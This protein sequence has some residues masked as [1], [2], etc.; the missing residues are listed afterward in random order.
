MC[1]ILYI[2]VTRSFFETVLEVKR[3]E[4]HLCPSSPFHSD[5]PSA[6][7]MWLRQMFREGLSLMS[8]YY[9]RIDAYANSSLGYGFQRHIMV[10]DKTG[11]QLSKVPS[12]VAAADSPSPVHP[13][14]SPSPSSQGMA[15]HSGQR[16][17]TWYGQV[18]DLDSEAIE[19][20]HLHEERNGPAL[21]VALLFDTK[22]CSG[23]FERGFSVNRKEEKVNDSSN[24]TSSSSG[25][26]KASWS[27][28]YL[29]TSTK[30]GDPEFEGKLD[31]GNDALFKRGGQRRVASKGMSLS[32]LLSSGTENQGG[33]RIKRP[34]YGG[35]T[36]RG[37]L[38]SIVSDISLGLDGSEATKVVS[39][40][41]KAAEYGFLQATTGAA[42]EN[43][44][45][46]S[47]PITWPHSEMEGI[48]SILQS[49][50]NDSTKEASHSPHPAEP[51]RDTRSKNISPKFVA[52]IHTPTRPPRRNNPFNFSPLIEET[53]EQS[54]NE[55]VI[56]SPVRS[57]TAS[58]TSPVSPPSGTHHLGSS[59]H[60]V[61]IQEGLWLSV[62]IKGDGEGGRHRRRSSRGGLTDEEI[63]MWLGQFAAKL[64]LCKMFC[65]KSVASARKISKGLSLPAIASSAS[66]AVVTSDEAVL[67]SLKESFGMKHSSSPLASR[68]LKSPYVRKE[69]LSFQGTSIR[70]GTLPEQLI[71]DE[72]TSA[73]AFFLGADLGQV[74][75]PE[76]YGM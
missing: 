37:S 11:Q 75:S 32:N 34:S 3:L 67:V 48:V 47:S 43:E 20:L 12:A 44:K 63:R 27:P 21:A 25:S 45:P 35:N 53:E 71:Q 29:R 57:I 39:P 4:T 42:N 33:L 41:V 68:P 23:A 46:S 28:V 7:E 62:I 60:L 24:E 55:S 36:S 66:R 38:T 61:Q 52:S 74:L 54:L 13:Q 49:D 76:R 14:G 2:R 73:A 9:D 58:A 15:S 19:L 56:A 16:Q 59:Y 40:M 1:E 6:L 50:N 70:S 26:E 10:E 65:P 22:N 8:I 5:L 72:G 17:P 51:Q 64:P 69:R 30:S 18:H 31:A